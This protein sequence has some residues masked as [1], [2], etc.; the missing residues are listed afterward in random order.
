MLLAD[1]PWQGQNQRITNEVR[2]KWEFGKY[3]IAI[4]GCEE[5]DLDWECSLELSALVSK[6]V[7]SDKERARGPMIPI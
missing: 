5:F 1:S 7:K 2:K 6:R 3:A 4:V